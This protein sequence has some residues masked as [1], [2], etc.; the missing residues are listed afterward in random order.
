M[1]KRTLGRVNDGEGD[2]GEGL[3]MEKRTVGGV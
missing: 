3:M 1:E 2:T